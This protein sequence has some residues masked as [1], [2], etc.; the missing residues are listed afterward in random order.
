MD[1]NLSIRGSLPNRPWSAIAFGMTTLRS[2]PRQLI[3]HLQPYRM[4]HLTELL[5]RSDKAQAQGASPGL[6]LFFV[7]KQ[8][9]T[10]IRIQFFTTENPD[11]LMPDIYRQV[12]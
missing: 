6:H 3:F 11:G 5:K 4:V 9:N 8:N 2:M 7:V 12:V 10:D 1:R